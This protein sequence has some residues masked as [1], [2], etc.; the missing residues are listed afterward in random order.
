[1]YTHLSGYDLATNVALPVQ[2]R[3]T[4]FAG[5]H[6]TLWRGAAA[7]GA[8]CHPIN[9]SAGALTH[10]GDIAGPSRGNPGHGQYDPDPH[11]GDY[12]KRALGRR[13][14]RGGSTGTMAPIDED[15]SVATR[16]RFP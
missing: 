10:R 2:Q 13:A 3:P 7:G 5:A 12:Q 16:P 14:T 11:S 1:M 4:G 9:N 8:E 15:W 6:S